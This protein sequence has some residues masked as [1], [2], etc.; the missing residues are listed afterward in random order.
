MKIDEI[1]S[2]IEIAG[3]DGENFDQ[4]TAFGKT[5]KALLQNQAHIARI[6]KAFSKTQHNFEIIFLNHSKFDA[7]SKMLNHWERDE[8]DHDYF[9]V[10]DFI[11]VHKAQTLKYGIY[12]EY[13]GRVS[14]P[15]VITVLIMGNISSYKMPLTP[16]MVAHKIA[17]TCC[18]DDGASNTSDTGEFARYFQMIYY[19][20]SNELNHIYPMFKRK[21]FKYT[22]MRYNLVNTKAGREPQGVTNVDPEGLVEMVSQ[23]LITGRVTFNYEG[24]PPKIQKK[25]TIYEKQIN[26]ILSNAFTDMEGHIVVT[27]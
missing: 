21:W 10:G 2:N 20:I 23:Y 13:E 5:D 9:E 24:I 1:I 22:G 26:T 11:Q 7:D 14:K 3:K 6:V 12:D 17:H 25:F 16:W 18:D 15:G 8:D 19:T 27:A 4:G